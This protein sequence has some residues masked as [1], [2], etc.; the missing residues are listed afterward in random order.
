M[1][2][3]PKVR[4]RVAVPVVFAG[5]AALVALAG[6][7]VVQIIHGNTNSLVDRPLHAANRR[8]RFRRTN[9]NPARSHAYPGY[10]CAGGGAA[11]A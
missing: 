1:S 4:F 8:I 2:G 11:S 3:F 5:V 10:A 7:S 9:V 6:V